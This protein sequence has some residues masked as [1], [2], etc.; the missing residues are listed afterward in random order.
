MSELPDWVATELVLP[1]QFAPQICSICRG[2]DYTSTG[3]CAEC[4]SI[5]IEL[6]DT[7]VVP[8]SFGTM[9]AK[10]SE[11]RDWLTHYKENDEQPVSLRARE[12]LLAF[13]VALLER[14]HESNDVVL[15]AIT[16]V[17]STSRLGVHP[18]HSLLKHA[19]LPAPLQSGIQRTKE[20]ISHRFANRGAY[21]ASSDQWR[22][23]N[24]LLVDDVYT[25][26][27]HAQSA[28]AALLDAGA[29]VVGIVALARR[30]NPDYQPEARAL[31]QKLLRESYTLDETV[32][33]A[34]KWSTG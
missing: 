23:R 6:G 5:E 4:S 24:V 14:L 1:S 7:G 26:G 20:P 29:H 9:Y 31:W 32:L 15:D 21:Q 11:L 3:Q 12:A 17:P 30:I 28:R 25:T 22:E 19:D 2:V 16:V 13:A 8:A 10:P 34:V 18:L 27:A 33:R